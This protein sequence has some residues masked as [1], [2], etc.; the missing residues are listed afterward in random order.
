[1]KLHA[2]DCKNFADQGKHVHVYLNNKR[3]RYVTFADEEGGWLERI[4]TNA[5]GNFIVQKD[6]DVLRYIEH[7]VVRIEIVNI[8]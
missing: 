1:M 5:K 2:A 8:H 6:D 7:G 4:A 3:V